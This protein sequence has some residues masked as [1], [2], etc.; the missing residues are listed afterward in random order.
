[1][2]TFSLKWQHFSLAFASMLKL[3][4][5]YFS[6]WAISNFSPNFPLFPHLLA[7]LIFFGLDWIGPV[8]NGSNLIKFGFLAYQKKFKKCSLSQSMSPSPS[9]SGLSSLSKFII[10]VRKPRIILFNLV[11]S[12]PILN[13][14]IMTFSITKLWL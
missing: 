6:G 1:M 2:M 14:K 10:F 5:C 4:I 12:S 8:Q 11:L 13:K 7:L 3:W 9:L